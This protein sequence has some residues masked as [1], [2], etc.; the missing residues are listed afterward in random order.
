MQVV[1]AELVMAQFYSSIPPKQHT[2][3]LAPYLHGDSRHTL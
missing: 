2:F 3:I 1:V